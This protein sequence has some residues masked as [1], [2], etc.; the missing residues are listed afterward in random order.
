MDLAEASLKPVTWR[1]R[2]LRVGLAVVALALV[3]AAAVWV[4]GLNSAPT[5]PKRQVAKIALLPDTPP[6]PP[7]P[8]PKNEPPPPRDE[9]R[10]APQ[11]D[12]PKPAEA[13]K[14]ANEPLKM[15][16]EAGN[17]PS[18]FAA[19]PVR[20][21]YVG[22]APGTGASGPATVAD[23]A[24]DRLYA[25]SVRQPLRDALERHLKS[26]A[27]QATAE[28]T[29]W[30]ARDGA[31][32]RSALQATGNPAL[33]AELT[34]ALEETQRSLRLPPPPNALQPLRFRLT[35]RPQG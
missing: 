18:A 9:A 2:A 17:G 19:G 13:D 3:V 20:N 5:T 10:P 14:P 6:P 30:L 22:G 26:E 12:A 34:A 31:I 35:L 4:K 7:P 28:F 8:P 1:T 15:E 11:P 23:R 33:D 24:Q 16:G 32:T 21:D 29:L 27:A 25:N